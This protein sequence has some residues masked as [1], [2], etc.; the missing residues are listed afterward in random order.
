MIL[1]DT[2]AFL[3]FVNDP[4]QLP[5]KVKEAIETEENVFISIASFWEM[6]I[7]SS[8]GML[9]LPSSISTMMKDCEK[10]DISI[11]PIRAEHLE[12]LNQ[13]PWI[14]KDPFDRLLICQAQA[15]G[16]I[17]VTIDENIIKYDVRTMWR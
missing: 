4:S 3:W 17:F 14:H 6:A 15:E 11:L 5:S 2:H 16:L 8:K 13:L 1:L 9:A 10:L 12:K 7:K